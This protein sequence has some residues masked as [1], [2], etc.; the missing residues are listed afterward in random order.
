M[1]AHTTDPIIVPLVTVI[2]Q[3]TFTV[4]KNA[5]EPD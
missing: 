1:L 5:K 4:R 3:T 2:P